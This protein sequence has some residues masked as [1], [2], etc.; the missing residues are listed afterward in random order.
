MATSEASDPLGEKHPAYA[1]SLNSLGYSYKSQGLFAQAEPLYKESLEIRKEVL[2][3]KHPDYATSLNNLAS[4]YNNQGLF[5]KAE[6]L[7]KEAIRIIEDHLEQTAAVQS[8]AGQ[9]AHTA[10]TRVYLDNLLRLRGTDATDVYAVAF[11]W[12]GAVTARQTF[13]RAT[14]GTDAASLGT[15]DELRDVSRRLSNLV[16]NPPKPGP[17]IDVP[18]LLQ[19]LDD[20][21]ETLEKSLAA[22]STN[23]AKYRESRALKVSDIQKLLPADA[24][25]IDFLVYGDRIAAFIITPKSIVRVD[26]KANSRDVA[27]MVEDFRIPL[28]LKRT[29]PVQ[30]AGDTSALR[31]A[32]WEPL[33]PHLQGAN[34]VSLLRLQPVNRQHQPFGPPVCR[35][36]FVG[37]LLPGGEHPLVAADVSLDGVHGQ[38][39]RKAVGQFVADLGHRPVACETPVTQPA[40]Y[41]PAQDPIGHDQRRLGFRADGGQTPGAGSVGAMAEF[42]GQVNRPVAGEEATL[43]MAPNGARL[44]ALPADAIVNLQGQ[45]A[46][47]RVGGPVIRHRSRLWSMGNSSVYPMVCSTVSN[48][49]AHCFF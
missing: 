6:P 45:V 39:D 27:E 42:A 1:A 46:E 18:K 14:R 8:E 5:A 36:H 49:S 30:G 31:E 28:S 48:L 43:T 21:R 10:K 12:R 17:G 3:E 26:L 33:V 29:R 19:N 32:V 38:G 40:E 4:L 13:A 16:N 25:L 23:F 41:I 34:L 7:F 37:I 15:L 9:L 2:G 11:R 35:S 22:Q 20:E 44:L 47:H 24:V